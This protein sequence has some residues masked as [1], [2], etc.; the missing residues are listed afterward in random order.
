MNLESLWE[1]SSVNSPFWQT[2]I[3]AWMTSPRKPESSANVEA[4]LFASF[5]SFHNLYV[6]HETDPSVGSRGL[7]SNRLR[8]RVSVVRPRAFGWTVNSLMVML[9]SC[10]CT[11]CHQSIFLLLKKKKKELRLQWALFLAWRQRGLPISFS[12]YSQHEPVNSSFGWG[13]VPRQIFNLQISFLQVRTWCF[14]P[15]EV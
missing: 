13:L 5:Y 12:P 7:H 11:S 10:T 8:W 6:P 4:S 14:L 15:Q 3:H 2:S 9:F 1:R